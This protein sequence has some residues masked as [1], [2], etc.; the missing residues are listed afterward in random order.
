[1][2]YY[3]LN[4]NYTLI[5]NKSENLIENLTEFCKRKSIPAG[6]FH[7]LGGALSAELGYYH[8][9]EKQYQFQKLDQVLEIASLHGN[10]ALK[11]GEPFI[12]AHA[13]LSDEN[14][15]TYG[16]HLKELT[17]GGT[18]EIHMRTFSDTWHREYDQET[19]L[20]LINFPA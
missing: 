19:G 2:K 12:H 6:F 13:V 20:S 9:D 1:M 4:T 18:C 16:G 10:V 8:L 17:V 5:F 3:E 7:G 15:R 11:D 14:L